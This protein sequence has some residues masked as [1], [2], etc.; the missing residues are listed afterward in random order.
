MKT[1]KFL[2]LTLIMVISANSL[3]A[4]DNETQSLNEGSINDQFEFILRKSGNFKGTTGQQ[5]EAVNRSMF[6]T[7][8]AHTI[9]SLKTLQSKLDNSNSTIQTQQ[10]EID[11]LKSNLDTTQS[12]LDATNLEKNNM[13]LLGL[14]MSKT[15]YNILMWSIIA[16]LLTLL[17][18]FIYKFKSSNAITKASKKTLA[19]TEEEFEEHRRS[20]LEREQKVRRQLQDELNK[21]KGVN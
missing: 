13:S 8:Q 6:L 7:L 14:A 15:S 18:I 16:G 5:Y 4:Q 17:L 3:Y 19:E 2:G 9:D 1:L 20:A 10:K 12:T 11:D 21:Q